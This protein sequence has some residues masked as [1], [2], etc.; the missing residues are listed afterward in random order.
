MFSLRI[1]III[2]IIMILYPRLY[3]IGSINYLRDI[4]R[5]QRKCKNNGVREFS[6]LLFV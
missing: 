3:V 2:K 5:G 6:V 1:F 4:I